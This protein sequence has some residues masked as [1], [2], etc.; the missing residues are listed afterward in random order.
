MLDA[1]ILAKKRHG[2]RVGKHKVSSAASKMGKIGGPARAAV[3][4]A[5][6]RSMV[7]MHAANARWGLACGCGICQNGHV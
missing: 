1:S 2:K 3:L 5:N 6:Q 4:D 7:A